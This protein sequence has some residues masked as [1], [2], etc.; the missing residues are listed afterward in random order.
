MIHV[1]SSERPSMTTIAETLPT[2]P[3]VT[4]LLSPAALH[5]SSWKYAGSRVRRRGDS[6]TDASPGWGGVK[7]KHSHSSIIHC[8]VPEYVRMNVSCVIFSRVIVSLLAFSGFCWSLS[9]TVRRMRRLSG[10]GSHAWSARR[11]VRQPSLGPTSSLHKPSERPQTFCE[12]SQSV[13]P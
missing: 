10:W 3:S 6:L 2:P 1:T 11:H 13:P 9:R 12:Q 7:C 8:G 4:C 5:S